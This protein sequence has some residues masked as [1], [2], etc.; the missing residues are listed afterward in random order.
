VGADQKVGP[1]MSGD[2]KVGPYISGDLK[3]G[4]YI[5]SGDLK[6]GPYLWARTEV[7]YLLAALTLAG[8]GI[9]T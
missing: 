2:L 9:T 3:V 6:V 8:T 1:N 7:A 4:P 5:I